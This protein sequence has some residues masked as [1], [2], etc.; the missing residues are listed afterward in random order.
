MTLVGSDANLGGSG[1]DLRPSASR[2]RRRAAIVHIVG[3]LAYFGAL[4][5]RWAPK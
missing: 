1:D 4:A 5:S 3:V 2:R